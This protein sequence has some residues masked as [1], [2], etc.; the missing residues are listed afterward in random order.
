MRD[1]RYRFKT[2]YGR[3][4]LSPAI[5]GYILNLDLV[6]T[7][8][9]ELSITKLGMLLTL[10]LGGIIENQNSDFVMIEL[11]VMTKSEF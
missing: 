11:Y 1:N 5:S 6:P 7:T 10:V 4:V 2:S 8:T 9:V 3:Q